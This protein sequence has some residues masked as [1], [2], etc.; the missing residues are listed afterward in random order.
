MTLQEAIEA[1]HSVRAYKDQPLSEEIVKDINMF[2]DI[3]S[4]D[5]PDLGG[6]SSLRQLAIQSI[7]DLADN[8]PTDEE[9][10]SA[11]LNLKKNLPERRQNN[12]YW[13]GA[14][15]SYLRY[16]RD[17]DIDNE[18]AINALTKEKI[19]Q[20]LQEVLTQGNLIEV[21]MRPANAAE[22]E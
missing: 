14:I 11:V 5:D 18:A 16:G 20:T 6:N 12:S 2:Y 17:I 10:T 9:V 21:V 1:R 7:N 13:E 22:A 19:Q 4:Q 15:E 3:H 8:G